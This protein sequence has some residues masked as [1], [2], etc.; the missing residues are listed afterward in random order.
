MAA[1]W[2]LQLLV[3]VLK[4]KEPSKL[5]A[6]MVNKGIT[7]EKF[8][9]MEAGM[10]WHFMNAYHKRT[11]NFGKMP[12]IETVMERHPNLDL[13]EPVEDFDDLCDKVLNNYLLRE[14]NKLYDTFQANL[15]A[16][17]PA[18]AITELYGGL[19]TLQERTLLSK[20]VSFNLVAAHEFM[21][22]RDKKEAGELGQIGMPWP[23]PKMNEAT[24]A[25]MPGDYIMIW[26]L[27]K[28]M[29]TWIGLYIATHLF[30]TGRRVLIYSKEMMWPA[31]RNRIGAILAELDYTKVK[32]MSMSDLEFTRLLEA[33]CARAGA[34][35]LNFT[36]ADRADGSPGGPEEIRRKID[37]YQPDFVLLDSSYMLELPSNGGGVNPYDWKQLSVINRELKQIAKTTGIPILS[38]LQE[39]E[40]A[41][42]KYNKMSRGTASL[43]MNTGAVMDCDVGIRLVYHKDKREISLHLAA[44]RETLCPGF[45]I[46]ANAAENFKY[47]HDDLHGIEVTA[48]GAKDEGRPLPASA[49]TDGPAE[50]PIMKRVRGARKATDEIPD[51]DYQDEIDEDLEE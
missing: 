50:S 47:A 2:E 20:D 12:S 14:A 4:G 9:H 21:E 16:S 7:N 46:Y 44:A 25:I 49:P 30:K 51:E 36:T 28:S 8:A 41:A 29:K 10:L 40:R 15:R 23:W 11:N 43:A 5:F 22:A 19:G 42:I 27:P 17:T 31:L 45:T 48:G 33:V 3:S 37:L 39:N 18:Q 38:I 32:D 35:E 1:N 24:Q 34:G 6:K 26:A 13:P